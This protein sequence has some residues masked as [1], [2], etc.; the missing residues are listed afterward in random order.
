MKTASLVAPTDLGYGSN[1]HIEGP[2]SQI[3][4]NEE[5][6]L[7]KDGDD[8]VKQLQDNDI[9]SV[10][11]DLFDIHSEQSEETAA[12]ENQDRAHLARVLAD[13]QEMGP[14]CS[15]AIAKLI[16]PDDD[17]DA[18]NMRNQIEQKNIRAAY[19]NDWM[20][21]VP[22]HKTDMTIDQQ[23]RDQEHDHE[24][25]SSEDGDSEIEREEA[26]LPHLTEM[27]KF[28]R[29][30]RP[31]Q[32]L[33][34]EVRKLLLLQSL[35]HVFQSIPKDRIWL[36]R[37]Q[38]QS[39]VNQTK[40]FIEDFTQL[41]WCWWPLGRRMKFLQEDE[42]RLFWQCFCGARIWK[43]ISLEEAELI[44]GILPNLDKNPPGPHRCNVKRDSISLGNWLAR[45]IRKPP[46]SSAS[47][48]Y[49]PPNN[50]ISSTTTGEALQSTSAGQSDTGQ[51]QCQQQGTVFEGQQSTGASVH[52]ATT[53]ESS[54]GLHQ[55]GSLETARTYRAI[56][57]THM[58]LGHQKQRTPQY[59]A[60]SSPCISMPATIRVVGRSVMIACHI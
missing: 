11:S 52:S 31:F 56:L 12:V 50:A 30:S 19:L 49:T 5:P 27:E 8:D 20:A 7:D 36:S 44:N 21:T 18:S 28:F 47:Q 16:E 25:S 59:L 6:Y 17:E 2:T 48:R 58:I 35:K 42:T 54:K 10:T 43:E 1:C 60:T 45:I 3:E 53:S 22:H 14:L 24:Y 23:S 29:N 33:L 15:A 4:R 51:D 34:N 55:S 39:L 9:E 38:N 26:E 40:T 46:T 41:E 57:N 32:T 13:D 37:Q